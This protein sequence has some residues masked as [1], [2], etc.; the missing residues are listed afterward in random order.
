[1]ITPS[2][3]SHSV[4]PFLYSSSACS[5][6]LFLNSLL[7]LVLMVSV[8]Y[9]SHSCMKCSL[10]IFLKRYLVFPFLLFSLHCSFKTPFL[11]LLAILWNPAI[12]WEYVSLSHLPF[13]SFLSSAI[14]NASTDDHF[15]LL[16]FFLFGI[17]SVSLLKNVMNLCP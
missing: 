1:M 16:H 6:H 2:W 9:H 7:W 17:I 15:S 8:L 14:Q 13:T 4:R 11:F 3:L 5:C 12:S 10:D